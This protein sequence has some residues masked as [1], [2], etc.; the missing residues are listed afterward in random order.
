MPQKRNAERRNDDFLFSQKTHPIWYGDDAGRIAWIGQV[1]RTDH[2]VV[3]G[4]KK[5]KKEGVWCPRCNLF[6]IEI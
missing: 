2:R 3:L 6:L 4:N 5:K 1:L